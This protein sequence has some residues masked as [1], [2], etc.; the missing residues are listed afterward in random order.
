[1]D[2]LAK[3]A[4]NYLTG[5]ESDIIP[6]GKAEEYITSSNLGEEMKSLPLTNFI[7]RL[8]NHAVEDYDRETQ[9]GESEG[10]ATFDVSYGFENF[11]I[12]LNITDHYKSAYRKGE[13]SPTT[14]LVHRKINSVAVYNSNTKELHEVRQEDIKDQLYDYVAIHERVYEAF[15]N[16]SRWKFV[17]KWE[18]LKNFID[19][20]NKLWKLHEKE[21]MREEGG[22]LP[23]YSKFH[24]QTLKELR[25]YLEDKKDMK[26]IADFIGE[27]LDTAHLY[28]YNEGEQSIKN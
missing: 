12:I 18:G 25:R 3:S 20:Q 22:N 13:E 11:D 21:V 23:S 10:W 26:F 28:G 9:K 8:E 19:Q 27:K 15:N 7:E 1:M 24:R 16:P 2:E 5:R 4:L 6:S 17:F 14:K